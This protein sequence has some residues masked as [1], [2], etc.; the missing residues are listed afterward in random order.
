VISV[1]SRIIHRDEP[2]LHAVELYKVV[3]DIMYNV[4]M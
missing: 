4:R 1:C 3:K 2:C